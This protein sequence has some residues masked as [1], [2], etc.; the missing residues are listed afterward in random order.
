MPRR[1]RRRGRRGEGSITRLP[2]GRHVARYSTTEGGK[3]VRKSKTFDLRNDAEWWLRQ[4]QRTGDAPQDVR[5]REYMARWLGGKRRIRETTLVLYRNHVD[6]IVSVLGDF[7]LVEI[8]RR[9]VEGF[10]ED[11]LRYVSPTTKRPLSAKTVSAMLITLRSALEAA[12]PREIP[13]NPAARVEGPRVERKPVA[14]MTPQDARAIVEAVRETWMEYPVR[15]L[16]GSGMRV[17][18]AVALNQG[19]VHDGWVSLRKSKTTLRRVDLSSDADL[20]IHEA[21][22]SAPRVGKGEPVFF[23][24]K[25]DR[26][27]SS[28]LYHAMRRD[29]GLGPHALRHAHA[30]LLV[31]AGVHMRTVAEQLGHADPALTARTYAHIA[32][33]AVRDALTVLDEV[34]K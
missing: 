8:Q 29:L 27:D 15:V 26:L 13:D 16:L 32:P 34:A 9:H 31:G 23:G 30:T 12:V 3:R 6:H 4:A 22:R 14:A 17:G 11:R 33:T 2:N 20:A 24:V 5:V 18:E 7:R 10:V 28:S 19:D 1:G 21:L 25:G